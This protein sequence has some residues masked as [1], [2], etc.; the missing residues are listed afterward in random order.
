MGQAVPAVPLTFGR[1]DVG[2]RD[3]SDIYKYS[4]RLLLP[5]QP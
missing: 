5:P 3:M 2:T 1:L 4:D